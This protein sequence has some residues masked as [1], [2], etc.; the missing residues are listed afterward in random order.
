[1]AAAAWLQQVGGM[2]CGSRRVNANMDVAFSADDARAVHGCRPR[3][4]PISTL[5]ARRY[6][7][8]KRA[9]RCAYLRTDDG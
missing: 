8:L 4:R 5:D 9:A 1:M 6:R 7:D 3:Y 2:A